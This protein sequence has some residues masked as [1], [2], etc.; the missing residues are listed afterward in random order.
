MRVYLKIVISKFYLLKIVFK[1]NLL[2]NKKKEI[3]LKSIEELVQKYKEKNKIVVLCNGPSANRCTVNSSDLYLVTNSGDKLVKNSDYLYYV[4][5]PL[6]VQKIL[7]SD[8]FIKKNA[9]ILFYYSNTD[10]HKKGLKFL[11]KYLA[12][13]SSNNLLLISSEHS[14]RNSVKN[15]QVFTDFYTKRN[16][17]VKIQNSGMFLVLFGYYLARRLNVAL[18][19]YGL[20]M[21]LGGS[22]HFDGKGII[23][24]SVTDERVKKNVKNYLDYIYNEYSGYVKNFSYFNPN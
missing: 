20:D 18:E 15:F 13:I 11:L 24:N 6:Y 4:N 23:G 14:D 8:S 7:S 5:D 3:Y 16:L 21:G 9:D 17:P 2:G 1:K 10:L 19:I 12:L 22:V